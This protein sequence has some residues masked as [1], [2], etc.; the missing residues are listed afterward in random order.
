MRP[1]FRILWPL[2]AVCTLASLLGAQVLNPAIDK[3]GAPF[4]YASASTDEMSLMD[5][6]LGTELTPSGY[7]YTG[8]G[9]LMFLVGY[10]AQ[11]AHQRIRT[12]EDGYLPIFH[13]VYRD[14]A[15]VYRVTTMTGTAS[16]GSSAPVNFIRILATNSGHEARTSYFTV[17]FRYTGAVDT[18]SGVG[19][20]RFR[21]PVV[22]GHPGAYSQPG[23]PFD[24]QWTYGFD[25]D[26]A[27]R[28]GKVVYEFPSNLHPALWLT[29]LQLFSKA[30]TLKVLPDTPV[31][32]AQY[33]V[34][35]QP[36]QVQTLDFKM[37]V[38]PITAEDHAAVASLRQANFD[39]A[40]ARVRAFWQGVLHQGVQISVPEAKV[41]D[42]F[43]ANL[44]DDMMARDHVGDDYIQTVNKLQY[45]AFWLRDG[46]NITHAYEVAG[47]PEL[48][49]QD[50]LFFLKTQRPDGLFLSQN[51]Q[52]DGWGQAVWAL[53]KYVQYTGDLGFAREVYPAVQKAVAWLKQARQ[54]DPLH[55][56]PASN[57][58]DDEFTR[59]IAHTTGFNIWALDGLQQAIAMARALGNSAD[60][61]DWQREYDDY[62]ATLQKQIKQVT[63]RTG[64]YIT[65]GLDVSGGQDWGNMMALY[66][67]PV[68]PLNDPDIAAT[69]RRT[70]AKFAEGLMT[71]GGRLHHYITMKDTET[72]LILGE[73]QWA[74]D[75]LYSVLVHTSSTHA[76]FEWGV[77]PW[78]DRDFGQDLAP[79]GWFS[80]EYIVLLR[81]MLLREQGNDLHLLSV[82]SPAWTRPGDHIDVSNA[83]TLF[84]P[85]S[86]HATF[87]SGGMT[88][89]LQPKFHAAPGQVVVH[90]PWYV[91]A[92]KAQADGHTVAIR[93]GTV[94]IPASAHR[95]EVTWT[96]TPAGGAY[97]YPAAVQ[98]W[99]QEY[100]AHYKAFLR[101]GSPR[102]APIPLK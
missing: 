10:P 101:N 2:I 93:Q 89:M 71:Y 99:K 64:G 9:E 100:A 18:T 96:R 23:V 58:H 97:S 12:L 55:L 41:V 34:H 22:P 77:R 19:T 51:G 27:L 3:A 73:Q 14:G 52:Y 48:A 4:S 29:Q 26:L 102:P 66:P 82:L 75:D 36:G 6:P 13:Y 85:V 32:L 49:R 72:E 59:T 1:R 92:S 31:L 60:A 50:L 15:V 30:Q 98:A 21:R 69:I 65:P 53:G 40:R 76:G 91:H 90:L 95:L 5:A 44:I 39:E 8:Y 86:L 83:P 94:T 57:P 88:L 78:A 28:S 24:S 11:P 62:S 7:L 67:E 84:G 80:A 63:A 74:L 54:Q 35:L 70:R 37:P 16:A 20:H 45:H 46:A 68:L 61:A 17:A 38:Q 47:Y 81:N 56:M 42:T 33:A 87:R 25:Q 79:H 43:K